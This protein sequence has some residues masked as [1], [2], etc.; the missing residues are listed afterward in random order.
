MANLA[1]KGQAISLAGLQFMGNLIAKADSTSVDGSHLRG[2][3]KEIATAI[4]ALRKGELPAVVRKYFAQGA[5]VPAGDLS[6]FAGTLSGVAD[7]LD[8]HLEHVRA[9]LKGSFEAGT[10]QAAYQPVHA[11]YTKLAGVIP[12]RI[13]LEAARQLQERAAAEIARQ[14]QE[15][16]AAAA[17]E[18]AEA[19]RAAWEA[20]EAQR[21]AAEAQALSV[22]LESQQPLTLAQ[23]AKAQ[24]TL[25][26]LQGG[27]L[28]GLGNLLYQCL[29]NGIEALDQL[30]AN[31]AAELGW[32][33]GDQRRALAGSEDAVHVFYQF[34]AR[35]N[36]ALCNWYEAKKLAAGL[37]KCARRLRQTAAALRLGGAPCAPIERD[38]GVFEARAAQANEWLDHEMGM[39]LAE[40]SDLAPVH[41][42]AML[43][44]AAQAKV[45]AQAAPRVYAQVGTQA[46]RPCV[47]AHCSGVIV[48]GLSVSQDVCVG[49]EQVIIPLRYARA[50]P[51]ASYLLCPDHP[52]GLCPADY[53]CPM[54]HTTLPDAK[55]RA[56]ALDQMLG[57]ADVTEVLRDC[58]RGDLLAE[59]M[60]GNSGA[61]GLPTSRRRITATV[62]SAEDADNEVT[63]LVV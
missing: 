44:A 22:Q 46:L 10:Y 49:N 1:L 37:A 36:Q 47:P 19:Q 39:A 15:R 57:G 35:A 24:R 33:V 6:A 11:A 59:I 50:Q 14:A 3:E 5:D 27:N 32:V 17:W 7:E 45:A 62:V 61:Y 16:A 29:A 13:K 25:D 38:A 55:V 26:E 8:V 42:C 58:L 51:L 4:Q 21:A 31:S 34:E 54:I 9:T 20:A 41:L 40:C 56:L 28:L 52:F 53:D 43:G 2:L 48:A 30:A 60:L 12:E 23:A 63:D 18:A